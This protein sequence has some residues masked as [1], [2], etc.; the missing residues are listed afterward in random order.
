MRFVALKSEDQQSQAMLFRPRDLLVRRRTQL[1]NALRGY[2]AEHGIIAAQGLVHVKRLAAALQ[3]THDERLHALV[4]ELGQRHIAHI[5][6]LDD[7]IGELEKKLRGPAG[8]TRRRSVW[9]PGRG[10]G[11]LLPQRSVLLRRRRRPSGEAATL[12]PGSVLFPGNTR[13]TA[14]RDWAGR[15]R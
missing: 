14:S 12:P 9:R 13:L 6:G 15:R 8:T 5:A 10:S 3:G 7:E 1:V 11:R 2:L 4:R